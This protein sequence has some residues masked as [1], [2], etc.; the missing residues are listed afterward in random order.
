MNRSEEAFAIH[1]APHIAEAVTRNLARVSPRQIVRRSDGAGVVGQ[2]IAVIGAGH[3]LDAVAEELASSHTIVVNSAIGACLSRGIRIDAIVCRESIDMSEQIRKLLP[4]R[5]YAFLDIGCHPNTVAAAEEVCRGVIWFIPAANHTFDIAAHYG[6]EPLY[7]GTSNV[8]AAVALAE[9]IGAHT[10]W[11]YGCSRAFSA[12][13]RAYADGTGWESVR[14]TEVDPVIGPTG[15]IDHY[16][17]RIEGT[18]AKE[19]L[20]VES[21]Q[22]PPLKRERVVPVTAVDGS[23]RWA[24]E[25][26][27]GDREWLETFATRHP[28]LSLGQVNPDVAI[29][30]WGHAPRKEA[31]A[32][33]IDYRAELVRQCDHV[34]AVSAAI[35]AGEPLGGLDGLL[36]GSPLVDF[37]GVGQRILAFQALKGRGPATQ[38][39]QI[40][41]TWQAAG[42]RVREW[43]R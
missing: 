40:L 18:E 25:P 2:R 31:P 12:D 30:G 8:T 34:D 11:L 1:K 33:A 17:G 32:R 41:K 9:M 13:G 35:L 43:M 26:L 4:G 29:A 39:P 36:D 37:A 16:V 6:T 10:V 14:L 42:E 5:S 38:V 19:R 3:T 24:V 7:G 21:G 23:Q 15:E 20:H 28:A 27:E 22:R